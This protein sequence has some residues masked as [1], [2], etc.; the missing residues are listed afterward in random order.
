MR[1][2][3]HTV[4]YLT[5]RV[6][7]ATA[8]HAARNRFVW[9]SSTIVARRN[10]SAQS[11]TAVLLAAQRLRRASILVVVEFADVMLG[12][13]FETELGDQIELRFEEVDM[14]F[15]VMHQFLEEIA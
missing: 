7:Q 12:V 4:V 2:G 13:K 6:A 14:F 1:I 11:W 15:L 9:N 5:Q 10:L 8:P 3:R